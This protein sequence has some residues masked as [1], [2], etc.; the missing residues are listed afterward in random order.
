MSIVWSQRDSSLMKTGIGTLFIKTLD[1]SIDSMAL[2]DIFP[3]FR[4]ILLC[5]L[6]A[7]NYFD[8]NIYV[9]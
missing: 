5:K 1:K 9:A 3:I 4:K 2:Y 6:Q 7:L 8:V